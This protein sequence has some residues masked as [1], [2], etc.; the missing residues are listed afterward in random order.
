MLR[1]RN[2]GK[3]RAKSNPF[4]RGRCDR[5]TH[6]HTH[7]QHTRTH[8]RASRRPPCLA[9]RSETSPGEIGDNPTGRPRPARR[10]WTTQ[11]TPCAPFS[12]RTN[13]HCKV[14]AYM[15]FQVSGPSR[16]ALLAGGL[17]GHGTSGEIVA[18]SSTL[19]LI[20]LE[21]FGGGRIRPAR[22]QRG[23]SGESPAAER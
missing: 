9:R 4:E 3:V 12:L 20:E 22:V 21:L 5:Y 16:H 15:G 7:T 2:W 19:G 13:H 1:S 14:P 23:V 17:L 10:A 18:A 11:H 6:T 8:T